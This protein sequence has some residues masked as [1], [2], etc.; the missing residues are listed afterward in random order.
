[1]E[2]KEVNET[3]IAGLF[4][5]WYNK[6]PHETKSTVDNHIATIKNSL[7][8]VGDVSAKV[9]LANVYGFLAGKSWTQ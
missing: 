7:K 8:N 4:D 9:L 2:P 6:Q 1:M 3:Q 5:E